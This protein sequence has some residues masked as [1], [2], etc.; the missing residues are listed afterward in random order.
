MNQSFSV[1][2]FSLLLKKYILDNRQSLI[3]SAAIVLVITCFFSVLIGY[4][5]LPDHV[6]DFRIALFI[7]LYTI[8]GGFFTWQQTNEFNNKQR[9]LALLLVPASQLEKF[10]V[11]F[12]IT[13]LCFGGYYLVIFSGI[14]LIGTYYVNNREWSVRDLNYIRLENM[15]LPIGYFNV[16]SIFTNY[17]NYTFLLIN[18]I[19]LVCVLSFRRYSIVFTMLTIFFLVYGLALIYRY[20]LFDLI[21]T[22]QIDGVLPLSDIRVHDKLHNFRD[23]FPAQPIGSLIRWITI[24]IVV[25]GWYATA[26]FRLKEREV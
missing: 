13:S 14:D 20:N 26:Y 17:S 10:L 23:I 15:K 2:R 22:A 25:I 12:T 1:K 8:L 7:N 24:C 21:D 19:I 16:S 3:G 6:K 9:V 5:G 4:S 11:L 18:P